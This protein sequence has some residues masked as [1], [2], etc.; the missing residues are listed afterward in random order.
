MPKGDTDLYD[1][2]RFT[3]QQALAPERH[4][5]RRLS[6]QEVELVTNAAAWSGT[7]AGLAAGVVSSAAHGTSYHDGNSSSLMVLLKI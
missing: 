3:A 2:P 1:R 6:S 7:L 5:D 4:M